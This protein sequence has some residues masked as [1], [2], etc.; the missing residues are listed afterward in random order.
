MNNPFDL[1]KET[2]QP[3][4][5]NDIAVVS[6]RPAAEEPP[7]AEAE[8]AKLGVIDKTYTKEELLPLIDG[9]FQHGYAHHEMTLHGVRVILR[10]RFPW[11][12]T[13]INKHLEQEQFKLPFHYQQEF[14]LMALVCSLARYGSTTFE[15]VTSGNEDDY[16]KSFQARLKFVRGLNSVIVSILQK[17]LFEFDQKQRYIV[18]HYEEL[19]QSF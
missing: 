6:D 17:A 2:A 12:D 10:T 7:T 14:N 3:V 11:E 9:M 15:P 13:L 5:S 16:A 4:V 18:E 1:T 8:L 19:V